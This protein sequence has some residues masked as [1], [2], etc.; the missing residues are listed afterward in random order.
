[1]HTI[2]PL[3]DRL[4]NVQENEIREFAKQYGFARLT[5]RCPVGQRSLRKKTDELLEHIETL[6]PKCTSQYC[7]WQ[8]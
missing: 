1:M 7:Q 5:C 8:G 4:S 6:Y 2:S 3:S